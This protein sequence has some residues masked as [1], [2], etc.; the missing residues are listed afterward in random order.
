MRVK[1]TELL[2]I[3]AW[4]TLISP[5]LFLALR[6]ASVTSVCVELQRYGFHLQDLFTAQTMLVGAQECKQYCMLE[7]G[8]NVTEP[9]S[10]LFSDGEQAL[11]FWA[12]N[13]KVK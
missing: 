4:R 13:S 2:H 6:C 12:S 7:A 11:I 9:F 1:V 3:A 10:F 5:F 8:N